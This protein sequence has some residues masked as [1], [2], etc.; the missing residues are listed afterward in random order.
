MDGGELTRRSWAWIAAPVI[1]MLVVAWA[2]SVNLNQASVAWTVLAVIG[3]FVGSCVLAITPGVALLSLTARYRPLGPATG[4]GLLLAGAAT[5][6]MA[7]FWAW[8]ASPEYGRAFAVL[9]LATS[10]AA[11]GVYG[12]RGELRRLGL[13]LPLWLALLVGLL[14]TGLAFVQGH[15]TENA[16]HVIEARYWLTQ[17][18]VIPYLFAKRVA[19]H[20]SVRGYLTGDWLFSDRPPLQTG[21]VLLQWPLSGGR[22]TAYQFLSSGLQDAWLP[23]LWVV[24]RVRE[25]PVRRVLAVVLATAATGAVFFNSIFVWPKMLA[26]A[27]ALAAFA[28]LVS[29]SALDRWPGAGVLVACLATLSMLAHGGTAFAVIALAPF[30][31]LFRRRITLRAFAACAG[32]ALALYVPWS[33]FQR[34]INP[35][36]DRLLKWQLAGVVAVDKRG[37]LQTLAQQYRALSLHQLLINKWD[38]LATLVANPTL[39]R[40]GFSDP[41]WHGFVGIARLAQ[42][43]DLLLAAGPLLLGAAAL[44]I[45]S[46]RRSL[47]QFGPPAVFTGLVLAIW[48]VLLWGGRI[49]TAIQNGPYA[50]VILFIGLCALAVT[51]LPKAAAR[52]VL[53]ASVAWFAI[54]WIP[55][56]GFHP[57]QAGSPGSQP[58]NLAMV[59]VCVLALAALAVVCAVAGRPPDAGDPEMAAAPTGELTEPPKAL[60]ESGD[61]SRA[62]D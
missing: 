24:L 8:F 40:T 30:A 59:W 50:A 45:P 31:Y 22:G 37:F 6:G 12:R 58:T 21:L 16:W 23:A 26:G 53:A 20:H 13:S 4:L 46:A 60:A 38:N 39:W 54:C 25:L 9:L 42:V 15:I 57:A 61:V 29:R 55:G 18:N 7:G 28:I 34:F 52:T 43:N 17:D 5:A 11:I 56:L 35:P 3:L 49:T 10:I 41:G 27:L 47:A 51:A 32:A 44:L 1:A 33:L 62:L 36:G 48:V 19:A 14:F 2:S